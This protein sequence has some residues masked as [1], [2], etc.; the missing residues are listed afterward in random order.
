VL[1]RLVRHLQQL[2]HGAIGHDPTLP[3]LLLHDTASPLAG[4]LT[5]GY[6]LALP[7]AA[8]LEVGAVPDADVLATID[9]LPPRSL[10]ILI[11]S[12][13]FTLGEFRFRLELFRRGLAVVE[14]P[15]LA[16]IRDEELP[17]Y[18]DALAYDPAWFRGVGEALKARLDHARRVELIGEGTA[19]VYEGPF[20]DTKR[21]LGDYTGFPAIGGQFP[22][23]EVFTEPAELEAVNGVVPIAAYGASDFSMQF[24]A[25][26]FS[27]TI[28]RGQVVDA[29]GAP[30][31][32]RAILDQIRAE[33]T[34]VWVRELGFGLNPAL[35]VHR[36]VNDVSTYERMSGVHLSL[37]AKHPVYPKPGF[38]KRRTRF[39]I[40]VF[41]ALIEA[42]IDGEVVY[43]VDHYVPGL[44]APDD[45][46]SAGREQQ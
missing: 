33:E 6:R 44:Q 38:A 22:I 27:L 4:L 40:D 24:Q 15:H 42:R 12:T 46:G 18:V 20:E 16:R 34:V 39:H 23:G 45:Q 43:R 28:E 26:P 3:A 35:T 21:N 30:D 29:P 41:P 8:S 37:G 19:L 31:D 1:D 10:V 7:H 32:F 14:H 9:R 13:R 5:E 2:T 25:R 17:V 11:Q 36:R